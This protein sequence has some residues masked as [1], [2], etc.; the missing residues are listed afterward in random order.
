MAELCRA[1]RKYR[2]DLYD[3]DYSRSQVDLNHSVV[4]RGL[5][6]A[7]IIFANLCEETGPRVEPAGDGSG[8]MSADAKSTGNCDSR[9]SPK[10]LLRR[11]GSEP[12]TEMGRCEAPMTTFS[13]RRT[14]NPP[15]QSMTRRSPI[16][17]TVDQRR[18]LWQ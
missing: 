5:A 3:A 18:T 14:N 7:S 2:D 11:R 8:L 6:R 9:S 16:E 12:F 10:A 17:E 4:M 15:A 13:Q 1:C